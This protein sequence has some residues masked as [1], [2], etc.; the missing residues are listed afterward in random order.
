[1]YKKS[2]ITKEA[3]QVLSPETLE[4]VKKKKVNIVK[5]T[6]PNEAKAKYSKK[7]SRQKVIFTAGRD[8]MQY[9][10]VV[11]P[12]ILRKFRIEKDVELDVLLY[13]FPFQYFTARDFK[14]LPITHMSYNLKTLKELNYIQVV[15]DHNTGLSGNIYGLTERAKKIVKEYYE[16]L[17]GEKTVNPNGYKNPFA[18]KEAFKVD[19]Q[20]QKVLDKLTHQTKTQKKQYRKHF[21]DF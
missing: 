4:K 14:A 8:L 17:S 18:D 3:K 10:I 11:R 12:Y 7:D 16:Y 1:M 9:N 15:V 6:H 5:S 2:T 20:R 13:L 19:A 21:Y